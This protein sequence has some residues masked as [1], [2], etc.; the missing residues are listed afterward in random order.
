MAQYQYEKIDRGMFVYHKELAPK[1]KLMTSD[2]AAFL[3]EGS[4]GWV[5]SPEKFNGYKAAIP[6]HEKAN[7]AVESAIR[8]EK[9]SFIQSVKD[10]I[11]KNAEIEYNEV[12]NLLDEK[13]LKEV[14]E[15][16]GIESEI[17]SVSGAEKIR[18]KL[19][20]FFKSHNEKVA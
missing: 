18:A 13:E 14:S 3:L 9:K 19:K 16:V 10:S 20:Q 15:S 6:V 2:K 12:F 8:D 11:T 7:A 1:G 17:K 5:D 4:D